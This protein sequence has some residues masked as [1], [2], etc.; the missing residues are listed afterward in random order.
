MNGTMRMRAAA[1]AAFLFAFGAGAAQAQQEVRAQLAARGLPPTLV[2]GVSAMAADAAAHGLPTG[3]IADKALEG[4]AKRASAER[5][6][7]V[8][9]GFTVRMGEARTA[10][11]SAG[12]TAPPGDVI[13]AAAEAMGRGMT[14]AQV[15]DVVRAGPAPADAAPALHVVTALAAQGMAMD[16]AV[17][18]VATAMREG[19]PADQLL[20]MPSVMRA[21]QARG[22]GPAEV[23]RQ[24]MQGGSEGPGG[25]GMG[26]GPG[27]QRPPGAGNRPGGMRPPGE[28]PPGGGKRP[29]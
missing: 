16:Q 2:D 12:V 25:P 7:A 17:T 5:I 6:L 27:G 3:P 28:P 4:W 22:M 13:A 15:G 14:G 19:R 8:V 9:Q 10:V 20:D 21:M 23:G 29:M 1:A 26:P 24:L 18:V 11:R